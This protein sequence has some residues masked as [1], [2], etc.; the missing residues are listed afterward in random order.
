MH[1]D[2]NV[3]MF[4]H[5]THRKM[6]YMCTQTHHIHKNAHTYTCIH[7]HGLRCMHI[8]MYVLLNILYMYMYTV[9]MQS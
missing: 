2:Y 8:Q 3:F 4:R 9:P 6:N 7:V 5:Y 1:I